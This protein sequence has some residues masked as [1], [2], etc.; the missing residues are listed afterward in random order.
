[1]PRLSDAGYIDDVIKRLESIDPEAMPKWGTLRKGPLIEH[2]IWAVRMS[3]GQTDEKLP[4]LYNV[5]TRYLIAPL[6]LNGVVKVPKNIKLPGKAAQLSLRC[7]GGLPELRV[8]LESYCAALRQ[9]GFR[10]APHPGFGHIGGDGWDRM[11]YRHLE[12]HLAQ[13]GV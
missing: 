13:F 11:H 4:K 1:M 12:H 7:E 5:V 10:P 9:P 6:V 2:M 3:M 8:A